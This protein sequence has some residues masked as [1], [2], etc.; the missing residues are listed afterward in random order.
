MLRILIRLIVFA[1]FIGL[2]L[3]IGVQW[4]L[5][6]DLDYLVSQTGYGAKFSYSSSS[7]SVTGEITIN[8]IKINIPTE[9]V[10][11]SV[12]QL[13][14]SAGSIL[15]MAF[16]RTQLG[17][18]EF[19][20]TLSLKIKE[21]II[22]L[23]P[24]LVE[25]FVQNENRTTWDAVNAS[26]CGKVKK[27]GLQEYVE[28]GYDYLVLS[29][30]MQ[31]KED[32][33]SGNL[34]GHGWLDI[35]ETSHIEFQFDLAGFYEYLTQK[36]I[37][38]TAPNLEFLDLV[39][40]DKGYN[41]HRNEFCSLKAGNTSE[42]YVTEHVKTVSQKLNSVGI[43]MTLSGE[44]AYQLLMQPDSQFHLQIKPEVSFTFADFGYYDE[45]EIRDL[46]GLTIEVNQ[47]LFSNIFNSWGLDRFNKIEVREI[48]TKSEQTKNR[49]F[50]NIIVHRSFHPENKKDIDNFINAEI[51][52]VKIDGKTIQGVLQR[53]E[54]NR[55]I[56]IRQTQGGTITSE[57]SGNQIKE[58]YVY[59]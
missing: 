32:Y 5:S 37:K 42:N 27:I 59:R 22:P 34:K 18:N 6:Q 15:D 3:Y 35:E 55:L 9:E 16:I 57:I 31:F 10:K 47:Q 19:P 13:K 21:A 12:N 36:D 24:R 26:A 38:T 30:E 49:F 8:D 33:Y 51:K 4:K 39:I 56:I 41:R 46:L 28:M 7:I 45:R 50:E 48:T 44:N 11:I 17:K 43:K 2:S 25:L 29:S 54:K 20:K 52:V 23:S 53:N 14:Y 40:I 1:F 58:F